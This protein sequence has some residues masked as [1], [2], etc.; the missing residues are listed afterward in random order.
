MAPSWYAVLILVELAKYTKVM[1]HKKNADDASLQA[2]N[3]QNHPFFKS[4]C[5]S[6]KL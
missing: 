5:S 6:V 2:Q 3:I 4:I 1:A